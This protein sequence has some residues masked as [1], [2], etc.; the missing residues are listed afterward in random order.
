M[1]LLTEYLVLQFPGMFA[2]LIS[3]VDSVWPTLQ[4][5]E[6]EDRAAGAEPW[7]E[8]PLERCEVASDPPLGVQQLLTMVETKSSFNRDFPFEI[9]SSSGEC[10]ARLRAHTE[11]ERVISCSSRNIQFL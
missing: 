6:S 1:F 8:I 10:L 4:L 9:R 5:Y 11:L 2:V 7:H 3:T